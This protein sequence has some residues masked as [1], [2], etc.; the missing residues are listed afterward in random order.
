VSFPAGADFSRKKAE[1]NRELLQDALRGLSGRSLAVT[2][3]L[4][5]PPPGEGE[6]PPAMSE[7][8]LLE[9]LKA[10]FGAEEVFDDE[11]GT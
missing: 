2:F 7:D 1:A 3:D 5:A 11:E 9:R 10:E 8:E 4:G 6:A